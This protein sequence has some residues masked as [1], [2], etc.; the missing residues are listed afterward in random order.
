MR[1]Y[2]VTSNFHTPP[3]KQLCGTTADVSALKKALMTEGAK[4][5]DIQVAEIEVPD[6]KAGKIEF[7]NKALVGDL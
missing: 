5:K 6:D 2:L 4:R 1:T 3:K 7:I